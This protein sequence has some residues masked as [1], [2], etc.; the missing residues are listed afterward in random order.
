[1]GKAEVDEAFAQITG[2]LSR[3]SMLADGRL[4][5]VTPIARD[6]GMVLPVALTAQAYAAVT[7]GGADPVRSIRTLLRRA[8]MAVDLSFEAARG[9][10]DHVPFTFTRGLSATSPG[11]PMTLYVSADDTGQPVGTISLATEH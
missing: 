4:V 7:A 9:D 5:D 3:A 6:V 2:D 8:R 10:D 11:T 1:M